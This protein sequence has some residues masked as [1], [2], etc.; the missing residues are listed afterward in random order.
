MNSLE[1]ISASPAE[2]VMQLE[3]CHVEVEGTR[4]LLIASHEQFDRLNTFAYELIP[5][6]AQ[7]IPRLTIQGSRPASCERNAGRALSS[8]CA[9]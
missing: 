7:K 1:L 4:I 3:R 6:T 2:H 5:A 9:H 8:T